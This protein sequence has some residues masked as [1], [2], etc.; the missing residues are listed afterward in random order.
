M[1]AS[2]VVANISPVDSRESGG[3]EPLRPGGGQPSDGPCP[4]VHRHAKVVHHAHRLGDVRVVGDFR[5]VVRAPPLL[6]EERLDLTH[7]GSAILS[8][9]V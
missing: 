7:L 4:R 6:L 9:Q 5:R 2:S 1:K 8:R 3:F